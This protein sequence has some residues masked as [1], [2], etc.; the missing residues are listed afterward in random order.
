MVPGAPF[1][2]IPIQA[3]ANQQMRNRMYVD[4]KKTYFFLKRFL[5]LVIS[6]FVIACILSWLIP[7][8]SVLI[9]MG[10]AG[11]VFFVQ[12]RVGRGGKSFPCYKFRTMVINAHAHTTRA[13]PNDPRT[14]RIGEILRLYNI[15]EFPQFFNVLLGHMSVVGP[16]PHMHAD[17]TAFSLTIPGYKFRNFVKPGITGLAQAKGLHGP[18]EDS[19]LF[20]KRFECDAFY[21]RNAGFELDLNIIHSTISRRIGLFLASF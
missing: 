19:E 10:S 5:D 4:N 12:R 7:V 20:R 13:V 21:V 8:L 17:C 6:L 3:Q 1:I 16:R 2:S 9:K 18:A 11:P 14:T 15:D